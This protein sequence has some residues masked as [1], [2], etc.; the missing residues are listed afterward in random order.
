[1]DTLLARTQRTIK[2]AEDLIADGGARAEH[3][4]DILP[5]AIDSYKALE[6]EYPR[7]EAALER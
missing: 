3:G 6:R 7:L 4:R 2:V 1:M 5:F